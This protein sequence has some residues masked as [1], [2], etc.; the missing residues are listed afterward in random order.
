MGNRNYK[1]SQDNRSKRDS[2]APGFDKMIMRML[3]R[4]PLRLL[5]TVPNEAPS[6]TDLLLR[7]PDFIREAENELGRHIQY[8]ARDNQFRTF[9]DELSEVRQRELLC[10]GAYMLSEAG[11]LRR[12][13]Y[14]GGAA[15]CTVRHRVTDHVAFR[16]GKR[17]MR[18]A[19]RCALSEQLSLPHRKEDARPYE[20][21]LRR[22]TFSRH[23]WV[24]V[25]D[26]S[27]TEWQRYAV[28]SIA[29]GAFEITFVAFPNA[30]RLL[31]R[32]LEIFLIDSILW[33]TARVPP[34][35]AIA[36]T[37]TEDSL[38]PNP[39]DCITMQQLARIVTRV[40]SAA[41]VL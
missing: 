18:Q 7:L 25:P 11:Y 17:L 4:E 37:V 38:A 22:A 10:R 14:V 33:Q 20:L 21:L 6:V 16:G 26:S 34:L 12:L 28:E 32:A 5:P 27:L 19:L 39:T 8:T 29:S 1:G 2:R 13:F 41:L 35:N 23:Q 30:D 9:I 36:A 3:P 24:D 31:A 15:G 40:K